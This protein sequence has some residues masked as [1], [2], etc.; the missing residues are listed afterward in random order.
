ME[1]SNLIRRLELAALSN[2][3]ACPPQYPGFN[4]LD[5]CT[6]H[7]PPAFQIPT[8]DEVMALYEFE[9]SLRLP[10]YQARQL[11]RYHP[12]RRSFIANRSV[13]E[14]DTN[15]YMV[16]LLYNLLAWLGV[17]A[18]TSRIPFTM[19]N[20][21]LLRSHIVLAPLDRYT[22]PVESVILLLKV[23][24]IDPFVGSRRH[25]RRGHFF[26]RNT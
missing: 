1:H 19:R 5:E 21:F 24:H 8:F 14:H 17:P 11:G 23:R 9:D 20:M 2:E 26:K 4:V 12:Y 10:T 22:V 6:Q 15:K 25:C 7:R 18:F 16:R 3:E 13:E